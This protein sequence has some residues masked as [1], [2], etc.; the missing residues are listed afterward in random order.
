LGGER[1]KKEP[2][3]AM[4]GWIILKDYEVTLRKLY[5]QELQGVPTG[6]DCNLVPSAQK[7][8]YDGYV[9]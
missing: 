3:G 2:A 6:G 9:P 1:G 4:R 8:S 5:L 7:R